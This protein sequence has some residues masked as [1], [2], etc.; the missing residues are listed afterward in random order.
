MPRLKAQGL[1]AKLP[2][3]WVTESL[4]IV[5]GH[6]GHFPFATGVLVSGVPG[7]VRQVPALHSWMQGRPWPD[8]VAQCLDKGWRVEQVDMQDR[9]RV[10]QERARILQGS[11][12]LGLPL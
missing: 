11:S 3:R 2:K 6:N 4:W 1:R 10:T 12:Q 8:V 7:I 9:E 5:S